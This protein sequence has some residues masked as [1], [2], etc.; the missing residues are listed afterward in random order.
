MQ[1]ED[2]IEELTSAN[3]ALQKRVEE[4]AKTNEQLRSYV[5]G[6]H[7]DASFNPDISD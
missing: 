4:L 7:E 1:R 3:A 2:L 5:L 6:M